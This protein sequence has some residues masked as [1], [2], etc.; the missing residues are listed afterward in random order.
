MLTPIHFFKNMCPYFDTFIVTRCM[1]NML[2]KPPP[3]EFCECQLLSC[4]MLFKDDL[5]VFILLI[6]LGLTWWSSFLVVHWVKVKN[7]WLETVCHSLHYSLTFMGTFACFLPS[8]L[9][10][11]LLASHLPPS[12]PNLGCNGQEY[13]KRLWI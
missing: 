10:S 7:R 2:K 1:C 12:P 8:F 9:P 3:N 4:I 5:L 11:F 13:T 6:F